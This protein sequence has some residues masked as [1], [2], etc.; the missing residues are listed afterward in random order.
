MTKFNKKAGIISTFT[1]TIPM[2]E[3][4]ITKGE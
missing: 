1:F 4:E 3:G 2:E